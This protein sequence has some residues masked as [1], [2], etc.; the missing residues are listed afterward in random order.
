MTP[1]LHARAPLDAIYASLAVW[2]WSAWGR[3]AGHA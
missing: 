2:G 3:G 1:G